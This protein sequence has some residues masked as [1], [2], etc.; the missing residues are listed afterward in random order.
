M[1]AASVVG[2]ANR[3]VAVIPVLFVQEIDGKRAVMKAKLGVGIVVLVLVGGG[4][5]L[6]QQWQQQSE[7]GFFHTNGRLEAT[8]SRV[9]TRIPGLLA[10]VKVKEGDR[11]A[12]GQVLAV[13]DSKPLQA[14][15]A[16][17]DAAIAQAGDQVRLAEAQMVQAQTECS[18]ARSQLGAC[19]HSVNN[20]LCRK[21][22]WTARARALPVAAQR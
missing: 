5:L 15:I 17:A 19:S 2:I 16:R 8:Q 13:L 7:Q 20:N 1:N 21:I 18:Y 3:F 10:E 6:W 9:A 12:A 22:S 11:V 14:E 4:V